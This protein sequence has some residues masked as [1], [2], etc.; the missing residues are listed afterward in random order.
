MSAVSTV[1]AVA[2]DL[3]S[4]A[5]RAGN[6]SKCYRIYERPRDRLKQAL[7]PRL[8]A[9]FSRPR[10]TLLPHRYYR[11]HWALRNIS[12][13][14]MAGETVGIVG[15]NGS[16][17][18]TLLELITGILRPTDGSVVAQG[19]IAALLQL[20]AGFNPEFSGR[21]NVFLNA[22][23]MGLDRRETEER[24]D[25]IVAFSELAEYIDRPLRTYSSGMFV[26]LAFSVAINVKP[27]ILVIDEALAVGDEAFQRKCYARIQQFQA[28]GGTLLFVSHN[29]GAVIE[30]CSR[31][32]LLDQGEMLFSGLPRD[33]IA[34][35]QRLLYAPPEEAADVRARLRAKAERFEEKQSGVPPPAPDAGQQQRVVEDLALYDPGM[36][37]RST[38][39][40]DHR[41][42]HIHDARL[43]SAMGDRV[44]LLVQRHEYVFTYRV[45]F[46]RVAER[47]RFGMF[48]KTTSGYELGGATSAEIGGGKDF[49]QPGSVVEVRF[50]F[51]CLL[52]PGTY[53][54]NAGVV[55]QVDGTEVFLDRW[56]DIVMF[57]VIPGRYPLATGS[58]DLLI[59]PSLA[60]RTMTE[61]SSE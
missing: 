2:T 39:R 13:E 53:F 33:V 38:L 12:L 35:Y 49:P 5:V 52:T 16:G 51:K 42:A 47:T 45:R 58:V 18:S 6:L 11:E 14:I 4:I 34:Q 21:E 23:L 50:H 15:R 24:F 27:S 55:G 43:L 28:Q 36:V 8:Q 37:P 20:G 25:E 30:L 60:I 22:A 54:L 41:G 7:L 10:G 48:I 61:P 44:N 26:R 31:A 19:R 40:Y 46:E 29:S 57:K 17:K 9:L 59:E 1:T 56:I 32:I 3:G